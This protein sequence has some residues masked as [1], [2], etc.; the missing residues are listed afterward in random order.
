MEGVL[1][2]VKGRVLSTLESDGSRRWLYPRLAK[3]RFLAARRI[4]AYALIVIFV[5]IPHL[6]IHGKP[7]IFLDVIHRQ[8]TLLGLT[9]LPTDMF[10]LALFMV[11]LILGVFFFTALFGRVWCGWACPQTVYLEFLFRPIERLCSGRRGQGGKPATAAPIWLSAIKYVFYLAAA[12]FLAHTFLAYFVGVDQLRIWISGSPVDHPAAFFVMAATTG[13]MLFDFGFF[14]EQMCMI[15]CPYGRFQSAL[16]DRDSLIISYDRP[17]GEPRGKS[18]SGAGD[19]IDCTMC[20]QVCPTGIDIRDGLQFECVGCAQ[21]I[22]ACDQVMAKLRRPPGLIRYSSQAAMDGGK[23]RVV[24]PRIAIYIAIL[25]GFASLLAF[26]ISTK[27]PFDVTVLRNLG[28][29]FFTT[30]DGRIAN[31][32][33]VKITNRADHADAF[34][35]SVP[36]HPDLR[37]KALDQVIQIAPG[38]MLMEPV[39]IDAPQAAF[40]DGAMDVTI[41]VQRGDRRFV[42]QSCRLLGPYSAAEPGDAHA[43]N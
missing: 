25:A 9:F 43:P 14:R 37:V 18:A 42:E 8:F 38:R 30:D 39:E 41:R 17:R 19:C 4:V 33:R 27:S 24:R 40:A 13:L 2:T 36:N 16:L 5:L 26:L 7:A 28:R 10:L 12:L 3:G 1:L 34:L 20:V 31:E 21:C 35:I 11:S 23:R 15:A 22:D 29:P 6:K 32:F